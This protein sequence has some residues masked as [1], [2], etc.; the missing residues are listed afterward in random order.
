MCRDIC[1]TDS[2]LT[3]CLSC[4]LK[5]NKSWIHLDYIS[6]EILKLWV[7]INHHTGYSVIY[8]IIVLVHIIIIKLINVMVLICMHVYRY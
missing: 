5:L 1:L 4:M 6:G 7:Q 2:S 3:R 8:N